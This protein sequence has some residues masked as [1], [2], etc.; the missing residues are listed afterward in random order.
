MRIS[1]IGLF[2]LYLFNNQAFSQKPVVVCTASIFADMASNIGGDLIEV[3]S[4]VPIGG[5][6]HTYEPKP[7][8]II[9]INNA[10]LILKNGLTFEK[11]I[12]ELIDNSGTKANSVII[13]EGIEAI[14]SD[15][16]ENSPDPHAWMDAENGMI[17]AKNIHKALVEL[18]P[19]QKTSLDSRLNQYLIQINDMHQYILNKVQEIPQE[20]RILIT[21]HDAFKYYGRKYDF[22][23]FIVKSSR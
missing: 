22:H 13:T 21:S 14:Q 19:E 2:I 3:K 16:Y 7:S 10:S 6:P 23:Q 20:Q 4:I 9:K 8:D 15:S 17:Y 5:D 12:N 18:L 11:W 1:I